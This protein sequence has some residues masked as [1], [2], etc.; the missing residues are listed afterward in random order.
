MHRKF[1]RLLSVCVLM[2]L[3]VS[4][5]LP[6]CGGEKGLLPVQ[7]IIIMIGDGM[8]K[9]HVELCR[10]I[11]GKP[12]YMDSLKTKGE[13]VTAS[14]NGNL[15][16]SAA[17]ATAL[18]TGVKTRNARVG[19]DKDSN[20][21]E[22][23]MEYAHALGKKTGI[24]TSD[25]PFG[26][27]PGAFSAHADRRNEEKTILK[28]QLDGVLDLIIGQGKG[29]ESWTID[30]VPLSEYAETQGVTYLDKTAGLEAMKDYERIYGIFQ[31]LGS[32]EL[33]APSYDSLRLRDAA[34]T[35]VDFLDNDKGF[36]LM[37]EG[38]K[39]DSYSH[40]NMLPQMV[41]ELFEFDATVKLMRDFTRERRD[42]LLIVVADHECGELSFS[43]E[44]TAANWEKRASYG[45][46][47]HS[48]DN[49]Y[50]FTEGYKYSL[51]EII[52]NT[53]IFKMMKSALDDA[54][55]IGMQASA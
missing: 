13:C 20:D 17:A 51:A 1:K 32:P 16:D 35:A 15:T 24:V 2:V 41:Y 11:G 30:D 14:L 6:G 40:S 44:L 29:F 9:N 4:F 49:V 7:N 21:L 28:S 12:L 25:F 42:T 3:A 34:M 23:I 52:D 53:D 18:A 22:S 27:T 8:G 26:A 50:Y 36:V 43:E 19:R 38:S 55:G 31:Y 46:V 10:V 37:V 45:S 5:V 54:A 39:T 47:N 33:C 48:A